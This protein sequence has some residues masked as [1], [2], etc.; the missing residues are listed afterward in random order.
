LDEA[1]DDVVDA[2]WHADAGGDGFGGAATAEASRAIATDLFLRGVTGVHT[3]HGL[4]TGDAEEAATKRALAGQAADSYVL[5]SSD[6]IG[7]SPPT[8]PSN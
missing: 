6:K 5:A 7:F 2:P 3:Q 4:T 1:G 8:R